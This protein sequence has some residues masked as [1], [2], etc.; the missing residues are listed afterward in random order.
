M[1][2]IKILHVVATGRLSGAEKVIADISTNL[3]DKYECYAVCSGEELK[4]YYEEKGIKSFII[5]INKLNPLEINKLGKLIKEYNIDLVHGHDVKPSI[6]SYIAAKKYKV[7]VISH[8]HVTYQ[9]MK[10]NKLMKS[11]DGFFRDKYNLSIACSELVKEYYEDN[12]NNANKNK[13]VYLDNAFNFN[14]FEKVKVGDRNQLKKQLGISEDKFV[15]G[16]L[17]RLIA[18]KGADLL[19]QSFYEVAKNNQKACLL[20]VGDGE[21]REKL[22]KLVDQLQIRDKVIF[23]GYQKNIYEYMN[24][25]DCFVLPSVREG[26]PIAVLESMAMKKPVIS[27]PVAGLAKLIENK[28]NGIMLQERSETELV[29]SMIYIYENEDVRTEIANN[30]YEC[31]KNKYNINDYID[32]LEYYYEVVLGRRSI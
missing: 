18:V 8:I 31:L 23:A 6:A 24:I 7:P 19:I 15:F 21:E 16:F 32:K 25:F 17:G 9:W 13:I 22:E 20:I 11:I 29:K 5:N 10:N 30:A 27:T 1:D 26:L 12:N 4:R 3:N 14:E 28:K 2:K